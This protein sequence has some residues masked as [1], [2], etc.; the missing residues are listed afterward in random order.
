MRFLLDTNILIPLEDS[1]ITLKPSLANFIRLAREYDHHLLYHPASEDDINRDQ[2]E[3]RKTRTLERLKLYSRLEGLPQCTWNSNV[4]NENNKV[5][6]EILFALHSH[7]VHGLITEDKGIHTN[8]KSKGLVDRVY[9]IQT[10][11]DLLRRLHD[12][13]PISLPNIEEVPLYAIMNLLGT[14]FFDS[15]RDGYTDFDNWFASKAR[16]GRCAWVSR[17]EKQS[18]GGICIYAE[19]TDEAI[20]EGKILKGRA[21]KL[22]TFKVGEENR[23]R[24]IG[25]LLLKTAFKYASLNKI[26][27]IFIHGEADK[28]HFLFNMLEDFGF[29][30]VGCDVGSD[31]RDIVYVKDSPNEPPKE[32]LPPFEYC[33]K[34]YPHFRS[35]SDIDHY[36]VPI[37]P[38]YHGILFPDYISQTGTQLD[39]F[40]NNNTAGNAIKQAYLCHA[41]TKNISAGS[42]VIF[43]RSGDARSL[44][45]VGI[46]ESY[47][48]LED[49]DQIISKV[50]RRTVYSLKEIL[51]IAR[52]PTKVMLFW[53]IRHLS[54]PLD[55]RWMEKNGICQKPQSITKISNEKCRKIFTES[56]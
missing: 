40:S 56:I 21:L 15:L 29:N 48:T 37:Q 54:K 43:Y 49:A 30:R 34:Y 17:E 6:N 45:T 52:K 18:L 35:D 41:Q 13:H 50:R 53:V 16:E 12:T 1:Q 44:T 4:T 51:D 7:A 25:E 10:A 24:K 31:G 27:H 32:A 42:V 11:E 19:Q 39:L 5:D 8:A 2:N 26:E 14:S 28:H 33:R 47:E 38:Q 46:V 20:T 55:S 23:G 9:T 3:D 22:S 36:I